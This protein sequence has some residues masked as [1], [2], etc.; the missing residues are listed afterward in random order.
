MLL[1]VAGSIQAGF[2]L[3]SVLPGYSCLEHG[4]WVGVVAGRT[5]S[6]TMEKTMEIISQEAP[7]ILFVDAD[8]GE[9]VTITEV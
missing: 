5:L 3:C 4:S 6:V 8:F 9:V 7:V 1:T 2:I